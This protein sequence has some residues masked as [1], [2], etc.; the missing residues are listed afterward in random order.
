TRGTGTTAVQSGSGNLGIARVY[1][2]DPTVNTALNA[3]LVF[4]YRDGELNGLS[5]STLILFGSSDGGTTWSWLGQ[6]ARDAASNTLTMTGINSFGKLTLG[7]SS[8]PLPLTWI[9]FSGEALER[10]NKLQ[11][12]TANEI[13]T[14]HFDVERS[15]TGLFFQSFGRIAA[16]GNSTSD[17]RYNFLDSITND[18]YFYRVKQ[19]DRNGRFS[20]SSVIRIARGSD[21]PVNALSAFPNPFNDGLTLR[22]RKPAAVATQWQVSLLDAGGHRLLR[23]EVEVGLGQTEVRLSGLD[24]IPAGTYFLQVAGT[25]GARYLLKLQHQATK[26]LN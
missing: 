14:S 21:Y 2:V 10:A 18:T 26:G 6:V 16:A 9:S 25:D 8:T 22:L 20:H 5:E 24:A 4:A 13:N 12:V 11:W 15:S 7:S 17:R 3:D 23:K 1:R 19:V